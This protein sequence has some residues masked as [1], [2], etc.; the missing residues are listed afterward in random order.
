M[1]RGIWQPACK[2]PE[3]VTE[4]LKGAR[5]ADFAHIMGEE[6]GIPVFDGYGDHGE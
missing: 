5:N 3:G 6:Y 2:F 4:V 1:R